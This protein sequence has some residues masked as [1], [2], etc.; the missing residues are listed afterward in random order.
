[1]RRSREAARESGR[2]ATSLRPGEVDID[3]NPPPPPEE[4]VAVRRALA[5][6]GG[7]RRPASPSEWWRVGVLENLRG[8]DERER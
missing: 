1:M 2:L 4:Q 5:E 3:V 7:H 8:D 6:L